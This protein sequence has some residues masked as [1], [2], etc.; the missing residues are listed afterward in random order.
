M[1]TKY[2][3][4]LPI[5]KIYDKN[6]VLEVETYRNN[7]SPKINLSKK[8]K[9]YMDFNGLVYWGPRK[10]KNLIGKIIEIRNDMFRV[11]VFDT[12]IGRDVFNVLKQGLPLVFV[13]ASKPGFDEDLFEIYLTDA[14]PGEIRKFFEVKPERNILDVVHRTIQRRDRTEETG[15]WIQE[16]ERKRRLENNIGYQLFKQIIKRVKEEENSVVKEN[17]REFFYELAPRHIFAEETLIRDRFEGSVYVIR[18]YFKRDWN[19]SRNFMGKRRVYA[20]VF[21]KSEGWTKPQAYNWLKEHDIIREEQKS[22]F[23][24][25]KKALEKI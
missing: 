24:V 18:G 15:R 16:A 25:I 20:Y 2:L 1:E 19:P 3:A 11:K 4:L 23:T 7:I 9:K 8:L 12:E 6:M 13:I 14:P 21:P 5:S 10:D 17:S 22:I